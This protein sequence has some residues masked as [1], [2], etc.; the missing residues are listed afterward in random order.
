MIRNLL[1]HIVYIGFRGIYA[2]VFT[3]I[4]AHTVQNLEICLDLVHTVAQAV[5][6]VMALCYNPQAI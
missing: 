4:S 6:M 5:F 1:P 2:A 3:I